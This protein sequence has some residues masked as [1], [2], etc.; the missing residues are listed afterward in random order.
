LPGLLIV[1]FG[2]VPGLSNLVRL[3]EIYGFVNSCWF[4]LLKKSVFVR[5]IGR[6]GIDGDGD[7]MWLCLL[8]DFGV[9]DL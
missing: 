5:F 8:L 7:G 2:I 4:I 6:V 3:L 9:R 1:R